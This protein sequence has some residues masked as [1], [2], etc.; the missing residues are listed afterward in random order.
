MREM[1][2]KKPTD[3]ILAWYETYLLPK[4]DAK[5]NLREAK[6]TEAGLCAFEY[7]TLR[8]VNDEYWEIRDAATLTIV[9]NRPGTY[10]L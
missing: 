8:R 1:D 7:S 3:L 2:S 9:F 5:V 6:P 4:P 10:G